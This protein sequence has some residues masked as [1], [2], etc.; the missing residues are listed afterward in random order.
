MTWGTSTS[1]PRCRSTKKPPRSG[2]DTDPIPTII[3]GIPLRT[4]HIRLNL[5]RPGF[6]LNPTN[7]DPFA[8]DS[9]LFGNEGPPR[10]RRAASRRELRHAEVRADAEAEAER[11]RRPSRTP[12][13]PRG[14][15]DQAGRSQ[16]AEGLGHPAEGRAPRQQPHQHDLHPGQLRGRQLPAGIADRLGH[17]DDTSARTAAERRGLSQGIITGF[18][19]WSSISGGRSTSSSMRGSTAS[20]AG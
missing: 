16:L 1:A 4:R 3:E 10:S 8:V 2:R 6:T 11:R 17:R 18:P 13:Y 9:V 12:G 19:T 14:P 5:D 7:C 20:R 15:A